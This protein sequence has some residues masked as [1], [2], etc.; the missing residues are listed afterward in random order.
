LNNLAIE[1]E[2]KLV[3]FVSNKHFPGLLLNI[4]NSAKGKGLKNILTG[5]INKI[6]YLGCAINYDF[7]TVLTPLWVE[8]PELL[9]KG[10]K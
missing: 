3:D 8:S 7:Q 6:I 9:L 2:Q 1:D 4:S 10:I 5:L